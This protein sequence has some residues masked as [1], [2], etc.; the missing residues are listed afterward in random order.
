[1]N[2]SLADQLSAVLAYRNAPDHEPE[3][4]QSN[5]T[6]VAA[7]DNAAPEEVV[8]FRFERNLLVTP[9]VQEIMRQVKAG[10]VERAEPEV[11]DEGKPKTTRG[12]I[13]A[14][15]R[16]KFSD[17]K[18]TERAYTTGPDG[19]LIQYDRRM[20]AGAMLHTVESPHEQAGGRGFT[21]VDLSNSNAFYASVLGTRPARF[22]KRSKRRNGPSMTAAE[23]RANLD[24]AIAN[25]AVMPE[26]KRYPPGLP[27][28]S[29]R[30]GDSFVGYLKPATGQTGSVAWQD[31]AWTI[32]NAKVWRN[33]RRALKSKD[34]A[35]LDA[36]MRAHNFEE[37]GVAAGQRNEYARR[38]GGRGALIAANDNLAAAIKKYV[39]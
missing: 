33:V 15:G 38:K 28:G 1:L 2:P 30:V 4:I 14:I 16:L 36:A 11:D 12:Q 23:S 10:P 34:V 32:E 35:V 13:I 5:W 31:V 39:A 20:E 19:D 26:V 6:V 25:T 9:S 24:A 21:D 37:V 8:D 22:I 7:N 29:E 27:C 18:Q 17:G 3:P